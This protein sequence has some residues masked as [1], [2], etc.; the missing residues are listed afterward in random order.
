MTKNTPS[1]GKGHN[2]L[3]KKYRC[4]CGKS[5]IN[6]YIYSS[7]CFSDNTY[8]YSE[9]QKTYKTGHCKCPQESFVLFNEE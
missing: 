2:K 8:S 7:T 6:N 4:K 1:I 3:L 5:T 9:I